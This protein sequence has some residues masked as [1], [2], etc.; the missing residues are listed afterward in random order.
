MPQPSIVPPGMGEVVPNMLIVEDGSTTD[1]RLAVGI[2]T[3]PPASAGPPPHWHERHDEGFYTVSGRPVFTVG[4]EQVDAPPG[5]FVMVPIGAEHTFANPG[6]EP[7]VILNTF[8]PDFY[9]GYFRE[10]RELQESGEPVTKEA[11]LEIMA[12]YH[13]YPAGQRAPGS[14]PQPGKSVGD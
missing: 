9:V 11:I 12:R 6:P 1:H 2:I 4:D 3:L 10:G 8:T 13:T 7:A 5:T 14:A